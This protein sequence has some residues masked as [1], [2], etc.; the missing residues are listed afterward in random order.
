MAYLQFIVGNIRSL[1][2]G[3]MLSLFSTF[4][5]TAFIAVYGGQILVLY[6]MTPGEY[7]LLYMLATL[8]SAALMI[9]AGKLVDDLPRV[10]FT[11]AVL[12]GMTVACLAMYAQAY[13]Q[14][15]LFLYLTLLLL[16]LFGQGLM[17]H[18]SM[19]AMARDFNRNRGKA[20]SIAAM[21]HAPGE[22][23]FPLIA[24]GLMAWIGWRESWL[25]FALVCLFIVLPLSLWLATKPRQPRSSAEPQLSDAERLA[26]S[27]GWTR[28]QVIRDSGFYLLLP[29]VFAV[30]CLGTGLFFHQVVL[31]NEKGWELSA[32]ASGFTTFAIAT[33]T[34]GLIG[35]RLIDGRNAR[36]LLNFSLWPMALGFLLVS[37]SGSPLI[38]HALM[39][40]V[41]ITVGFNHT[42][43]TA[44]WAE[45]YGLAHLGSIR[46]L[47]SSFM[48]F[49]TAL[50]P[51]MMG[52][53]LDQGISM[54]RV[55]LLSAVW[56]AVTAACIP[57]I[58]AT[59]QCR[60]PD[61]AAISR[62]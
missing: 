19:T 24:V 40:L 35:G 7:G 59:I 41:G 10:L 49:S 26:E 46:A 45:L 5:Q 39:L 16:R 33:T 1:S 51:A 14:S 57:L 54:D 15:M 28:K 48:V 61:L 53:L 13:I 44:L 32:F 23:F 11:G 12:V 62:R 38:V 52:L 50:G 60:R 20:L 8:S 29:V 18:A 4:G 34:F 56:V 9:Q 21:G 25:A 3:F 58:L 55:M 42:I 43:G 47:T 30:P 22:A 6:D 17:S 2:Y 31:V 37:L 27:Q 36:W